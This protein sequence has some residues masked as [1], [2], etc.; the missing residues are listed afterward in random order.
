M[1]DSRIKAKDRIYK[2]LPENIKKLMEQYI[3]P[4]KEHERIL[5]D[6]KKQSYYGKRTEKHPKFI[7]V[8]GQT[9]SGK[10]NLTSL[11]YTKNSNLII[12]DS[13]KYKA[14]RSDNSEILRDHF[15]EYAFLTAPDSYLHR[16]E[17]IEDAMKYKFN[18]LME[19][20]TSEKD[21][22]FVDVQEIQKAGYSVELHVL[23]VSSLNSAIS[24]HERYEA[25]I[26]LNLNTAKL[27]GLRR[28][29]DSFNSLISAVLD[30]KDVEINI[31]KR[32]KK[33]PYE[34][35]LVYSPNNKNRRF[36][37]PAEALLYTQRQDLKE[38]IPTVESRC[39]IIKKQMKARQA[40]ENQVRQLAEIKKR[41]E[42]IIERE[43]EK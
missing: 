42:A 1:I 15:A 3:L 2:E 9:G 22:L 34:P 36:S 41:Y 27:T 43:M 28:H 19:C 17:M 23:G 32:G 13:D 7:I 30:N 5:D 11:I 21:K 37:C 29:D 18:I 33:Y 31:Y 14:Y 4:R 35:E 40:P 25:L 20:A 16:D 24:V 12:I 39:E 8:A 10:S 6:I 38:T 26:K